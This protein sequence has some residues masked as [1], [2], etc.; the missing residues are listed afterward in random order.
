MAKPYVHAKSSAK[1]FGGTLEPYL[2][3]H[4]F[5][6]SSKAFVADSRHRALL[7][8]TFG[9]FLCEKVFGHVIKNSEGR[10]VSV[11]DI[12]EQHILEDY[13]FKFIPTPQ[14]YLEHMQIQ[15]WM[16]NAIAD[17]PNSAKKA[18]CNLKGKKITLR[19]SEITIVV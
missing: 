14:D 11:R 9:I 7:H 15:P 4:D 3:I 8:S 5:L 6:D 18:K 13:R 1:R 16:M 12:A 10:E 17:M 19:A 2:P